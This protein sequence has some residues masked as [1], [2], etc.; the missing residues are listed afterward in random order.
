MAGSQGDSVPMTVAT[1][2]S[3][4]PVVVVRIDGGRRLVRRLAALGIVPGASIKVDR[5]SRPALVTVGY[6][7][8]AVGRGVALSVQVAEASA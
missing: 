4:V 6:T 1:A 2:P 8:I 5:S 7:R 3:Q